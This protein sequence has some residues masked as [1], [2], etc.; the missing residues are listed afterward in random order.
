MS[1][2]TSVRAIPI[3]SVAAL[4]S[5]VEELKK[6]GVKCELVANAVPR[7]YYLDQ[8][9]RHVKDKNPHD[10]H[11]H[12]NPEEC[13]YVLRLDDAFY[14]IGF[15]R[16]K[17]GHLVPFFDDYD[18]IGMGSLGKGSKGIK[19]ILGAKFE[20]KTQHWSGNKEA[21]DQQRHSV[22]LLMQGYVK[23]AVMEQA[24]KAGV[25]MKSCNYDQKT[26][27]LKMVFV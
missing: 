11:F 17:K 20:G 25:A 6:R 10:Y 9:A 13:D 24:G 23:H 3:V 7:M 18:H 2:T 1:H 5:A 16:D 15:L 22:G 19:H 27:K 14:D 8:I 26:G 21:E 4:K 12:A